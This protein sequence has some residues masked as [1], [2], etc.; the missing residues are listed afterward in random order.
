MSKKNISQT[1]LASGDLNFLLRLLLRLGIEKIKMWRLIHRN[2]HSYSLIFDLILINAMPVM[3][4]RKEDQGPISN[5]ASFTEKKA[6]AIVIIFEGRLSH[7]CFLMV[8]MW[9]I[10]LKWVNKQSTFL[11][12]FFPML[13]LDPPENIRKPFVF[14]CFQGDQ[15][16]TLGKIGLSCNQFLFASKL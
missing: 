14:W 1:A 13:P 5:E 15:K 12:L 16:E 11:T 8:Q 4:R 9:N 2:F 6:S 10:G 7:T 3:Y